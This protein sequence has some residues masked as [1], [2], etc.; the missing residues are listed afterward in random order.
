MTILLHSDLGRIRGVEVTDKLTQFRSLPYATTRQ[1]FA[2]SELLNHLPHKQDEQ[3]YDATEVGP[4]SVQPFG[5]AH[6]DA[7]LC[8]LPSDII[9]G[10]QPQSEDCLRVTITA[11]TQLLNHEDTSLPALVFLHGG[12][13]FLNSGE[14]PCY[15][16]INILTQALSESSP[17]V[18]VS[19]NYRLGALGFFHSAQASDLIPANNGLHDQL[20][21]FEWIAKYIAG[22]GGDP[23]NITAIGQS[24]GGESLAMHNISGQTTPLY[25]RSIL[26]SGS[27]VTM[28]T[29]TPLEH[30][31]NFRAQAKKLGLDVEPSRPSFA[32]AKEMI[33]NVALDA[34]RNLEFIGAPCRS[35]EIFPYSRPTMELS[36]SAP[37]T[38]VTWLESQ[39]VSAAGYDGSVSWYF[40]KKNPDRNNHARSFRVLAKEVLGGRNSKEL[41]ELYEIG[42]KPGDASER[43]DD[44]DLTK[45]CTF[46]T[47]VGFICAAEAIA[48]GFSKMHDKK[49]KTFYQLFDLPNPFK[50]FLPPN[51]YATHS[52]DIVALL[53]AFDD[54]LS[55][56]YSDAIKGWRSTVIEYCTSG[57]EPWAQFRDG[58]GLCISKDG[59][60]VMTLKTMPGAARRKRLNEIAQNVK[61]EKGHDLLWQG[62]C[63]RWLDKGY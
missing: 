36:R 43:E 35:S 17:L 56:A 39:I 13:Y 27:L 9:E 25:K 20:R 57:K 38:A 37:E 29:K 45:I 12:A 11:P 5:A 22:F 47:D 63:G 49:T 53:G 19:I 41:C 14:R 60:N 6:I 30:E 16:P 62:F 7:D 40:T 8:Q 31:E 52:W 48:D 1:R 42:E 26:L 4:S 44:D 55:Q 21:A 10:D 51:R 28:P 2:R 24:A 34:I 3:I 15:S 59:S 54:R 61:G 32:I 50:G 58:E 33:H 18:F 23:N 46:E